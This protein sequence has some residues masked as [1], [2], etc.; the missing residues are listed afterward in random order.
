MNNPYVDDYLKEVLQR[1][2]TNGVGRQMKV[3]EG[4]T[5]VDLTITFR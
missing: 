4:T 5:I 1:V 2:E 3:R